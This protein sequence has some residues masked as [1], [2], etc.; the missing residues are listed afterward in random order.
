MTRVSGGQPNC[1]LDFASARCTFRGRQP[2]DFP[3]SNPAWTG[4]STSS[5]GHESPSAQE[6]GLAGYCILAHGLAQATE[7]GKRELRRGGPHFG[8]AI[9]TRGEETGA[10][11]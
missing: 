1:S 9:K 7:R 3:L 6:S 10:G 11:H 2:I 8:A 5:G 4:D